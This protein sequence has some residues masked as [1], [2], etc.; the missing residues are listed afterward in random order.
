MEEKDVKDVPVY[1]YSSAYASETVELQAWRN[2]RR[3]DAECRKAIDR[4]I[5]E[6][7]DGAHLPDNA[8]KGVIEKFGAE[9]VA[10]VLADALQQRKIPPCKRCLLSAVFSELVS[11]FKTFRVVKC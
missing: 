1:P 10:Y 5:S 2:S 6:Q 4:A 11:I 7:W 8:A 9:R 3:A